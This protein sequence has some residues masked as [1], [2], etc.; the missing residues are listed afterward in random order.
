MPICPNCKQEAARRRGGKCPNCGVYV[1]CYKPR[2]KNKKTIWV[3]E[4]LHTMELIEIMQ[5]LLTE[6]L[7][8]P[9]IFENRLPEVAMA[10]TLYEKCGFNQSLA[11]EVIWVY[12]DPSIPRSQ[13]WTKYPKSFATILW[14]D[15]NEKG[16]KGCFSTALALAKHRQRMKEER[17]K[18]EKLEL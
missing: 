18:Q 6:H 3:Y 9:F 16:A 5:I 13:V 15:V 1:E 14:D 2:G 7:G 11:K 17:L 8:Y 12:F 4:S 10:K